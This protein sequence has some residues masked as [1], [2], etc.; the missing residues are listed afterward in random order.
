[1]SPPPQT[2]GPASWRRQNRVMLQGGRPHSCWA[3]GPG[4]GYSGPLEC[5]C[6]DQGRV[7]YP[8]SWVPL[9]KKAAVPSL[10]L[11][12]PNSNLLWTVCTSVQTQGTWA[13]TPVYNSSR[14][15]NITQ[16][17]RTWV[18]IYTQPH[19]HPPHTI[20]QTQ[21]KETL[22]APGLRYFQKQ[23]FCHLTPHAGSF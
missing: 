2:T 19:I 17:V 13:S 5:R 10:M 7:C 11:C 1:M 20:H 4:E 21:S 16:H 8:Y 23:T 9:G 12:S 6:R 3:L 14:E 15:A 18:P 22:G